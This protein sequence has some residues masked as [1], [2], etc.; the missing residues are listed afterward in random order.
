MSLQEYWDKV[1]AERGEDGVS[2]FQAE[3]TLSLELL[4]Q[5]GLKPGARILDIGGGASRL[6]DLLLVRGLKVDV[7][8]IS[9][10]ALHLSRQ[11]LGPDA[12]KVSWF[13]ADATQWEPELHVYDLWHDR[14]VFHFLVTD[15]DRAAY[16]RAL[17]RGLK[18][19]GHLA[20]ASFAPEGPLKCS[21]LD[22]C[23]Y[24]GAGLQKVLGGGY[25]L[26]REEAHEHTTPW[27]SAQKFRYFLLKKVG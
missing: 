21:G 13:R 26:L 25:Q 19:G 18:P 9:E 16:L 1:Y 10:Q 4:Q 20:L 3:P 24:D 15:A 23:R 11:R 14:A 22:V 12:D 17:D 27:D 8:D 6:V 2:W 5:A 7:L